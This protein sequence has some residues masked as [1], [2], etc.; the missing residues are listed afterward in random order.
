VGD[1]TVSYAVDGAG[2]GLVLV[3]GTAA[4]ADANWAHLAA[5]FASD[6]TVV[7]PDYAGSGETRDHGGRLE[8]DELVAQVA[9]AAEDA[10]AAP[11][12][13]VGFSLGAAVAASLAAQRPA[14]VRSL[15]LLGGFAS[16]T[17]DARSQLQFSL[18]RRLFDADRDALA[19]LGVLTGLSPAFLAGMTPAEL[20]EAITESA[21]TMP[22]GTG[23]QADLVLRV[24][25]TA[26]LASIS[27]PTLVI[28]QARDH[29]VPV[30]H[31][32]ALHAAIPGAAYAELDTGHL[33]LV[34]RPDLVAAT[35]RAFLE[36]S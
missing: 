23:R 7:R 16:T 5:R 9:G 12:D 3:H 33:G 20:E 8:L 10:G 17:A 14:S 25:I 28:G 35:I 21:R 36:R 34:E 31:S 29:V 11:F 18:W 27:A 1:A 32:R 19:G 22:P 6:R 13:L 30:E 15:V 4:S 2:P 24:D 26:Q